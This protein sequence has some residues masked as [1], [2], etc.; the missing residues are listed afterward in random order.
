M[1]RID[2]EGATNDN[3]FTS[4][5]PQSGVPATVITADW[6][7]AVQEEIVNVI[8]ANNLQKGKFTQLVEAINDMQASREVGKLG[9]RI[10]DP[11]NL[12]SLAPNELVPAGQILNRVDY[13]KLW[14]YIQNSGSMVTDAQWQNAGMEAFFSSGNGSTTF[15]PGNLVTGVFPR[16][17]DLSI[18]YDPDRDSRTGGNKPGSWQGFAVGRHNHDLP[19]GT[20]ASGTFAWGV[21]DQYWSGNTTFNNQPTPTS[22]AVTGDSGLSVAGKQA[23]VYGPETR[24]VNVIL[25]PTYPWK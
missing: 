3:R 22:T 12:P 8:G 19:T 13:P 25:L 9:F 20:A 17:I 4:G 7:N 23:G 16:F 24:S 5:N 1:H 11:N 2:G 15:R 18:L 6:L 10:C 14:D 21:I